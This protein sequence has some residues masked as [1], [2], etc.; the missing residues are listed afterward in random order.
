MTTPAR[1]AANARWE[2]AATRML[3][4][5][6][7]TPEGDEAFAAYLVA[8]HAEAACRECACHAVHTGD[9]LDFGDVM[10]R[11]PTTAQARRSA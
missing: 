11:S 3:A 1:C 2:E 6:R 8:L 9:A 10:H 7:G 4:T 5:K